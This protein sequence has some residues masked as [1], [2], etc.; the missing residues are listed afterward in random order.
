MR[1]ALH[2]RYRHHMSDIQ[3]ATAAA[4]RVR[5]TRLGMTQDT[6]AQRIEMSPGSLSA[7]LTGRVPLDTRDF[8]VIAKALDLTDAFAL[9]DLAREERN[10]EPSAA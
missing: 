7:R 4:V 9:L 6:L 10:E 5:L 1:K 2:M 8:D 3:T